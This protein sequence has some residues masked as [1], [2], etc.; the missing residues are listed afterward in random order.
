MTTIIFQLSKIITSTPRDLHGHSSPSPLCV[1][2]NFLPCDPPFHKMRSY[3]LR[4][5]ER[6]RVCVDFV[7]VHSGSSFGPF[8]FPYPSP[9]EYR[10]ALALPVHERKGAV[11]VGGVLQRGK[12]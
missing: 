1:R 6:G 9:K 5:I 8:L 11:E 7:S 2:R 10:G 4:E 12:G 3:V